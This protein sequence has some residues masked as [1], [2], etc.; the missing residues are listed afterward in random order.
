MR[1]KER[2]RKKNYLGS[3][4][5]S[6]DSAAVADA[7]GSAAR[8]ETIVIVLEHA[9][10]A[11]AQLG[12]HHELEL[13][14]LAAASLLIGVVGPAVVAP[15]LLKVANPVGKRRPSFLVLPIT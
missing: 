9:Q 13:A 4:K 11:N 14:L 1:G 8:D 6:L 12:R 10:L 7:D 2:G 3:I 5:T 15:T